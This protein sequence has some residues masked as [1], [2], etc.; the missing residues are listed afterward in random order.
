MALACGT[1]VF[2]VSRNCDLCR[3]V[4]GEKLS[5]YIQS[6]GDSIDWIRGRVRGVGVVMLCYEIMFRMVSKTRL[7]VILCSSLRW[8]LEAASLWMWKRSMVFKWRSFF[9]NCSICMTSWMVPKECMCSFKCYANFEIW[10]LF[11]N[12]SLCSLYLVVKSLS[13]WPIYA[14]LQL[15]QFSL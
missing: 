14:F 12:E 7:G 2:R 4:L 11:L 10:L 6:E 5:A 9:W 15:G 8:L 1:Y 13:L 3:T